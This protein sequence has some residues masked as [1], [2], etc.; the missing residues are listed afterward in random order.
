VKA[1]KVKGL[2]PEAPLA[3]NAARIVR[4]RLDELCSFVPAALDPEASET[5]HHM[6]IAAKRLRYVLEVTSPCFGPYASRAAKHA[7][8]LQDTIGEIHDCDVMLPL[9]LDHLATLRDED[10]ATVVE[11]VGSIDALDASS[12]ERTPNRMA[13]RPLEL[14]AVHQQARRQLCFEMFLEQWQSLERSAFRKRLQKALAERPALPD[15]DGS[16]APISLNGLAA[17]ISEIASG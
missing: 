17:A 10:V 11:R 6:R 9:I 12:T 15:H 5:L 7:R 4:V 13:Y 14:L 1:R 3:D 2:D 16:P 8:R